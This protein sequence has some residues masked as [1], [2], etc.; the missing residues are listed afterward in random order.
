VQRKFR[1]QIFFHRDALPRSN[2][3]LSLPTLQA[4]VTFA[5]VKIAKKQNRQSRGLGETVMVAGSVDF[6]APDV[7]ARV[8]QLTSAEIDA[9]P[10]GVIHLDR[11]GIVL[12]YSATEARQ[13]GYGP[14]PPGQDFFAVARKLASDDF[15]GRIMRAMGEGP[16]DFE[17]GWKGDFSDPKRDMRIRVQSSRSGGVWILVQR[18]PAGPAA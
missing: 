7:G 9:L 2:M 1:A 13:S 12:F 6:D 16:V 15:R 3:S 18:D 8:E 10:F 11:D 5:A 17:F 14:M 4:A